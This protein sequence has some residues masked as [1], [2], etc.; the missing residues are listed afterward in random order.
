MSVVSA[1]IAV[2]RRFQVQVRCLRTDVYRRRARYS[3]NHIAT[4]CGLFSTCKKHVEH[5]L[6]SLIV[7]TVV[8]G[9]RVY[10][11]PQR[12]SGASNPKLNAFSKLKLIV[13]TSGHYVYTAKPHRL[14]I[15][16]DAL[17]W[18]TCL[19]TN[20]RF[21]PK[22]WAIN[23]VSCWLEKWTGLLRSLFMDCRWRKANQMVSTS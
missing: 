18:I 12:T 16:H 13:R 1:V 14:A 20:R 5:S 10:G 6:A 17:I 15:E 23:S 21:P 3:Y 7:T 8:F 4:F 22:P 2:Q 19:H 11:K 9:G